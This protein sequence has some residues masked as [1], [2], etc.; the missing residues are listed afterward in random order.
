VKAATAGDVVS[1][2]NLISY[3]DDIE[4]EALKGSLRAALALAK[5]YDDGLGVEKNAAI[6]YAWLLIGK[7]FGSHDDDEPARNELYEHTVTVYS[8]LSR[9]EQAQAYRLVEVMC[10]P[11]G[12]SDTKGTGS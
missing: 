9:D 10:G 1:M 7:R 4:S 11:L 5:M 6:A 2:G 8:D 12:R 3:R